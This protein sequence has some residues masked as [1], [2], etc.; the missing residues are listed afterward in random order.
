MPTK[1]L[2]S[3]R[4]K[5]PYVATPITHPL[6]HIMIITSHTNDHH[7]T[8]QQSSHHNHTHDQTLAPAA[9]RWQPSRPTRGTRSTGPRSQSRPHAAEQWGSSPAWTAAA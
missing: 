2:F 3:T 9:T 1:P 4:P 8:H 5:D 7:I 6:S